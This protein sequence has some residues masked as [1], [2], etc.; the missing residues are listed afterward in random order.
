MITIYQQMHRWRSKR[1]FSWLVLLC[2]LLFSAEIAFAAHSCHDSITVPVNN[3]I[4]TSLSSSDSVSDVTS[5]PHS[6]EQMKSS[7]ADI[8]SEHI[9][10]MPST[11][12]HLDDL[13]CEA[14]CLPQLKSDSSP[15]LSLV[16][17]TNAAEPILSLGTPTHS[18][19]GQASYDADTGIST[20]VEALLCR[21][22]E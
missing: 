1:T 18:P 3:Q 4:Q 11:G 21:Y 22:R 12:D 10:S 9:E 5:M 20:E 6:L 15:V 19:H 16:A 7:V 13:V 14:H 17:I 8:M 2:G